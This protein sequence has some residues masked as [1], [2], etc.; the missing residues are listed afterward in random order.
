MPSRFLVILGL[1]ATTGLAV[2]PAA[3]PKAADTAAKGEKESC[4]YALEKPH[5]PQ[6]RRKKQP[7]PC[8][9][10]GG[11]ARADFNADGF[12]DLAVGVPNES[13]GAVESA[14][15]VQVIYGSTAG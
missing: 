2:T 3:S 8:G 4:E 11:Q 5:P 15:A 13:V 6:S 10:S 14:G 9:S 12:A 7:G 1:V